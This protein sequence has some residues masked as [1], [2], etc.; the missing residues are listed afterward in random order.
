LKGCRGGR[1]G[2]GRW[3]SGSQLWC[4]SWR[5]SSVIRRWREGR[6]VNPSEKEFWGVFVCLFLF[7][8]LFFKWKQD[9]E[10]LSPTEGIF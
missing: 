6:R 10:T 8:F 1:A 2:R 5:S 7:S 3:G 4:L 9:Y